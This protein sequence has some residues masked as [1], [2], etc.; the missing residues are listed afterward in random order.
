MAINTCT[1][2][3][4]LKSLGDTAIQ[5]AKIT[6]YVTRPFLHTDGTLVTATIAET[7]SDANGDWSL[8]LVETETVE[9]SISVA[10]EFP[11]GSLILQR[12]V[13][14]IIVPDAPT[15]NFSDLIE[16]QA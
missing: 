11:D 2:S 6:A 12:A 15:A 5:D 4:T 8:V 14:T 13:Y 16:G 10:I 9:K 3:G 7:L 1:V